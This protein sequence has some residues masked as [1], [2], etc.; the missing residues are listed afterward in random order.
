MK[1]VIGLLVFCIMVMLKD[2]DQMIDDGATD[3][4]SCDLRGCVSHI[5]GYRNGVVE[6][7]IVGDTLAS[8]LQVVAVSGQPGDIVEKK[9]DS[10]MLSKVTTREIDEIEIELRG[11]DGRLI[12]F[13]YGTVIITLLFKKV[14]V[15]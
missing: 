13:D 6:H 8:L 3:K 15:F 2:R 12:P 1:K 7:M 11:L 10:P 9:Y 4:Y 5:C 14:I